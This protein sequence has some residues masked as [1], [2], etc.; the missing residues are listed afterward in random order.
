MRHTVKLLNAQQAHAALM[1]LWQQLKPLLIAGHKIEVT[2]KT[3]TRSSRQNALLH[4]MLTDI[5][6][7][8]VWAGSKRDVDSWKRLVTA[9]WLRGRGEPIDYLPALDDHGVDIVFRKTSELTVAECA[10][11]IDWISA[12]G[13]DNGVRF[14]AQEY[15]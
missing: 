14:T 5:A 15:T 13:A 2:A 8:V 1:A 6:N 12:W 7:Q 10:E 4:A 9:A 11:L 3:E